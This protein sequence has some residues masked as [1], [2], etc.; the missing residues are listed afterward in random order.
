MRLYKLAL[1]SLVAMLLSACAAPVPLITPAAKQTMESPPA[2]K[3][4]IVFLNPANSISGAF[5][6]GLYDVTA[7]ERTMYGMLGPMSKMVQNVEPGK[8]R[9]MAHNTAGSNSYL[10]DADLEAGKRYYVLLRFLYGKGLQL[11]PIKLSGHADFSPANPKFAKWA[12]DTQFV[13]QSAKVSDW[14]KTYKA[15]V[16][17]GQ[18]AAMNEWQKMD[19]GQKAEFTLGKGDFQAL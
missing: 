8:H 15:N 13:D 1:A 16:D 3:A 5:L 10:L 11:R 12:A 7:A 9:F 4:Q 14:Y 17:K 2:D 6:V 18:E 19:A